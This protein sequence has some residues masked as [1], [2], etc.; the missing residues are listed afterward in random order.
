MKLDN[1]TDYDSKSLR[2]FFLAGLKSEGIDHKRM[3]VHIVNCRGKHFDGYG[4][5]KHIR[6]LWGDGRRFGYHACVTIKIPTGLDLGKYEHCMRRVPSF[7]EVMAQVFIHE[8]G[9]T[10]GLRHEEMAKSWTIDVSWAEGLSIKRKEE[11]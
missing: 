5:Y 4:F 1:Q 9:H 8:V 2:K 7:E 6:H 11:T 3:V 10:Q